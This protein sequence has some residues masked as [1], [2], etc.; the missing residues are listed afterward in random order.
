[1][2]RLATLLALAA[3]AVGATGCSVDASAPGTQRVALEAPDFLARAAA[4]GTDDPQAKWLLNQPG[5]VRSS[6]VEEVLDGDGDQT[7]LAT[8]WLLRQ[9]DEVRASYVSDVVEPQLP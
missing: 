1:V 9:S 4:G 6:Y 5:D 8:A 2:T 7:L 3:L